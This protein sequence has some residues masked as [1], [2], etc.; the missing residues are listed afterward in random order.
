VKWFR[1]RSDDGCIVG[2]CEMSE[3]DAVRNLP[4]GQLLVPHDPAV[5][6]HHRWQNA[7]WIDAGLP[8]GPDADFRFMR[9]SGY[10]LGAQVGA[11]MKFVEALLTRPEIASAVPD[12]VRAEFDNLAAHNAALRAAYPKPLNSE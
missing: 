11:L 9:R 5:P 7:G 6:L 2:I 1:V 10:D 8:H 4:R 12:D 3:Q